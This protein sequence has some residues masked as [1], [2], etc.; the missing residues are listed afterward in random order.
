M[1]VDIT[2]APEDSHQLTHRPDGKT[3]LTIPL[4][5]LIRAHESYVRKKSDF[6]QAALEH[7]LRH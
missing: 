4:S 1:L 3:I 7:A 5:V 6:D 2:L